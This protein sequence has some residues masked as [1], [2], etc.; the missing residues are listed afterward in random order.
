[1]QVHRVGQVDLVHKADDR[2]NSTLHDEGWSRGH[3]VISNECGI[4]KTGIEAL[5][6]GGDLD[7]IVVDGPTS[8]RVRDSS[9]GII[10][11]NGVCD[12]REGGQRLT[13]SAA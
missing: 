6:E 4:C 8:L 7:F 2:L 5:A 12:R 13:A 1:M 10:V 3:A 9:T 11:S